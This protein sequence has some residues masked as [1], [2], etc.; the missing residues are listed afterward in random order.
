MDMKTPPRRRTHPADVMLSL[1]LAVDGM[2]RLCADAQTRGDLVGEK[3]WRESLDALLVA[4]NV[5]RVART[6]QTWG[7]HGEPSPTF[8][9][10]RGV[11]LTEP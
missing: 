6:A 2:M 11:K 8:P 5:C 4:E 7:H 1:G 3:A 10:P 9:I